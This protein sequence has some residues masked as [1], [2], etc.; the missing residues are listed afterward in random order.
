MTLALVI[1]GTRSGK[2]E[3]AERLAR[4]TGLPV[5]Y[6]ATAD[7]GDPAMQDRV[8]AHRSRRPEDWTTVQAG[9]KLSDCLAQAGG[10][11]VLVDSLGAWIATALHRAG[12][13]EVAADGVLARVGE[14]TLADVEEVMNTDAGALIVVAEQAGEGVLPADPASRAWLD[15]LGD[16]TQRLAAR[17]DTVE[18]V[19]AGCPLTLARR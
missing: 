19:V 12:A 8:R 10:L 6:V 16:A 15:I 3:H 17:A 7:E 2:S 5:R 18:L 14:D 11:C 13:F 9:A 4:A 1:G